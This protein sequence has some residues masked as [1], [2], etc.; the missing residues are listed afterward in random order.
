MAAAAG[1]P[2]VR[3]SRELWTILLGRSALRELSQIEAELNKY[4]QRLLEGLSYYKP[5]SSSS[6]ERVKA[7]KDVASPLKELG[8]RISKFL[9][10]DEEQS[11]QLLQCY[12]QEDYRGTRDA[13]KTVL[14][15]E[16]QS[17]ALTLKIADYYYEERTCILRCVLHLLTYFQ[18]E[19]HP[20]RAEYADCVDKL[21]KELVLKYRQ[22]FEELY[23]MEAPTW[24]THGNLMTERQVSRWFVQCLREQSMLLE[25]IFLYYA[26]FEMSP[27]DLLILT[28]MFKDQGF[29][30]RQTNRHLVDETMDPFVDRIGYFSAL[31][32]VEGMDIESLH[33]CA[34]DDRRELHQF[35][36]DG[37][38]CQDMDRVMLTLGDI[39]H[40]AP[41]L[42]AWALLRH[43][44]N[45]EETSSVVR[46][47]G[48]TAIQLNVFQ[49]LTRLLRSLASGGNDCTTSTACMCVY[50]LLSFA[51]T[52]LELHTLGNQQDVIDTACEV[53]ADPSLPELFWGTEPTSGLGIILDSVCGMFPHLLSPLLQL[54]RAL[55][56]GKSTAK[57]LLHSPGFD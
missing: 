16:R 19:R 2:C 6:A 35:A 17:Q 5:P 32:L 48:G 24:E 23:R 36:Q 39:P 47:I 1:G 46:K 34:L 31:I 49:Y 30:S 7:N 12:L 20:Y 21:E 29:G 33:K 14:Q 25:I 22:Q 18:D 57:K 50:G 3:S 9:G 41:V 45:P 53:L 54:L 42:L 44:L 56:S 8:L 15:D 4:W 13:L 26:Y 37:L 43:T 55:V 11:V 51:L 40:H 28:K 10:L 38:V 52:S 27:N